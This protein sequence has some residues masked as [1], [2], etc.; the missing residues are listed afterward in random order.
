MAGSVFDRV[1]G[2]LID[3]VILVDA[4]AEPV[5]AT[6]RVPIELPDEQAPP[7]AITNY[8]LETEGNL[9]DV[10]TNSDSLPLIKAQTDNIPAQGQAPAAT[11]LPVVLPVLQ[12]ADLKIVTI[13]DNPLTLDSKLMVNSKPYGFDI[14][15]RNLA[16]H[17][18]FSKLG[19]NP[20]VDA[21]EEDLWAV[22]GKYVW[23][24]A[25]QRMEVVSSSGD[26][27]ALG[28]GARTV[29][30]T[31]LDSDFVEHTEIIILAGLTPVATEATDIYRINYF[32]VLTAGTGGKAAGN[33]DIR[34]LA[35]TPIYSR[36]P[37]GLTRARN[38]IFTVPAGVCL[39]ISQITYSI[40]SSKGGVFGRF[41]FRAN[42][43]E[44]TDLPTL[45]MY[46][47]SEIGIDSQ[48]FTVSLTVPMRFCSGVDLIVSV[49]GDA[50]NADA[51]CSCQYRG[52]TEAEA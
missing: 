30:L 14:A 29:L 19:F 6:N 17:L 33:I 21:D 8:A 47:Y 2:V 46:P 39:Y 49:Q 40:G 13:K 1:N 31:Y 41:S 42:Y 3:R 50:T 24:A 11:S 48:A 51:V 10:K 20:D 15:Q 52:W 43:N 37:T 35:D 45:V 44:L 27:A 16:G 9:A 32:W 34:N 28:T 23:P 12:A 22:G 26:D 5:T 36:I 18:P 4:D 25:G 38:V 7:A